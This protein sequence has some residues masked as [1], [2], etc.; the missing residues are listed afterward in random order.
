[1]L[2]DPWLGWDL[3]GAHVKAVRI[4]G[5]GEGPRVVQVPCA[6]WQGLDRLEQAME[7]VLSRVGGGCRRH[8]VTMTGE[9]ADL[10]DDRASG[11]GALIGTL[12][13]R[14]AGDRLLI[15]AGA[16]GLLEPEAAIRAPELVASANWMATA[17]LVAAR[18][19]EGLLLDLGSTTTDLIPFAQGRVRAIGYTDCERLVQQELI[20]TGVVRTPLMAV[21]RL[22]PVGGAWVPL[23]AEHF[24][25]M[26]DV[27]R[28]IG[29]LPGHAD[30]H[31]S[32]DG[33]DKGIAASA[34]RLARMVG[35]D[36]GSADPC[37]W[38]RLAA[39]L[40]E[41]QL[42]AIADACERILS[43]GGLSVEAPLVGAGVGSFIIKRLAERM[44]RPFI[45]FEGFFEPADP[46]GPPIGDCAPAA[47]VA[48]LAAQ[49]G[50]DS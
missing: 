18:I 39:F 21:A 27:Y 37:A 41:R 22:V 30:L 19:G 42:R 4:N 9:L 46:T 2:P 16:G 38:R 17:E 49:S 44:Q 11:V 34:R 20:Y 5:D 35:V 1:M 47:A 6:L 50:L 12:C 33:R 13:R 31:P 26:A 40:A 25:T 14:L 29:E 8:A 3:G 45:A 43:R 48:S 23:M 32:A 24:A 36:A 15:W 28:L 10:F 7:L